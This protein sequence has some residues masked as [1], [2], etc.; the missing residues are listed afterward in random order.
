M[1]NAMAALSMPA[2]ICATLLAGCDKLGQGAEQAKKAVLGNG[3]TAESIGGVNSFILKVNSCPNSIRGGL[4]KRGYSIQEGK[5]DAILEITINHTG[6]NLDNIPSFGGVGNKANY[7]V[8]VLGVGDK[9]LYQS[10]GNEGSA[11]M[12]ELC[13]DIADEITANLRKRTG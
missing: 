11:T 12:E 1:R 8:R 10:N 3:A 6:R 4:R 5:A 7:D 2:M 9:V 13:G